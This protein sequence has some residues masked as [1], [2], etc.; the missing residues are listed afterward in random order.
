MGLVNL[1]AILFKERA[2]DTAVDRIVIDDKNTLGSWFRA[3]R[4]RFLMGRHRF[5]F[6]QQRIPRHRYGNFRLEGERKD[7]SLAGFTND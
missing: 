7:R 5:E 3:I 1:I 6:T 4:R 2:G